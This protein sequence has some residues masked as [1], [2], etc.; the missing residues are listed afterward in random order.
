MG[1]LEETEGPAAAAAAS[2]AEAASDTAA[3]GQLLTAAGEL[4]CS[5]MADDMSDT[6]G[7][8]CLSLFRYLPTVN[9]GRCG[10]KSDE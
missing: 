2:D 5:A 4:S 8:L 10:V 6:C 1:R 9:A 3:G 7:A